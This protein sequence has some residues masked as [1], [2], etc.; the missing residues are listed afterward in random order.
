MTP[1]LGGRCN[2]SDFFV[3]AGESGRKGTCVSDRRAS[4]VRVH[5]HRTARC[6]SVEHGVEERRRNFVPSVVRGTLSSALY[7]IWSPLSFS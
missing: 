2:F 4:A 7:Y 5:A 3:F 6:V 1:F